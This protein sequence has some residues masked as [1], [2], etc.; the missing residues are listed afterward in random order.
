MGIPRAVARLLLDE[1]KTRPFSGSVLKLGR[2]HCFFTV[3]QLIG[4]AKLHDVALNPKK[5]YFLNK[6][7]DSVFSKKHIDDITF[8]NAI[9][10]DSVE[11]CDF[12]E[13]ERATH[14]FDLNL[15]VS[16]ELY[17]KFDVILDSGTLEHI[18]NLPQSLNNL[19]KM[20]KPGGRIIFF[21]PSSN[22]VDHGFYMFSPT[23]FY[24]YYT[25]NKWK[26]E[27]ARIFEYTTKPDRDL[28]N[29]YDYT[30]GVLDHLSFGGFENRGL[31]GIH[32]VVTKTKN[33]VCDIIPQQRV[34]V[35]E[36]N[37]HKGIKPDNSFNSV[38]LLERFKMIVKRVP[39]LYSFVSFLYRLYL[40]GI[41]IDKQLRLVS[42]Y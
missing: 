9:G 17:N 11:S 13:Y 23:L 15:P 16:D 1:C 14:V 31:L 4:W 37:K 3:D 18:F 2:Q 21:S 20:L 22:H 36:W 39:F 10:F 19:Y 7:D 30:P 6:T 28:W 12:S 35:R 5:H 40:K 32:F 42:R 24:D 25:A 33:S 26:I 29:I 8:F 27:T 38:S 41:P 34:F